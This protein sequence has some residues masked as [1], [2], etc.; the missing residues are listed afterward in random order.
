MLFLIP[1]S[2]NPVPKPSFRRP[3]SFPPPPLPT[4]R[5]LAKK[6]SS[7]FQP[8]QKS[9]RCEKI[10]CVKKLYPRHP[11]FSLFFRLSYLEVR[12]RKLISI[13]TRLESWKFWFIPLEAKG[14]TRLYII[15]ISSVYERNERGLNRVATDFSLHSRVRIVAGGDLS[16]SPSIPDNPKSQGYSRQSPDKIRSCFKKNSRNGSKSA[17]EYIYIQL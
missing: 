7:F 9:T 2:G 6:Y 8:D 1:K 3:P 12:G 14:G 17:P 15:K 11:N 10:K 5:S 13:R 16:T 4:F